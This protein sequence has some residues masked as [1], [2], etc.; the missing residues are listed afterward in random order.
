M[1]VCAR[2]NCGTLLLK[3][4]GSTDYKKRFCSKE[5]KT[6]DLREKMRDKRRLA[7]DVALSSVVSRNKA[8]SA[9]VA[10]G[11]EEMVKGVMGA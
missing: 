11:V 9:T 8:R 3:P 2:A 5:C 4:D 10:T 7:K 1:R 6:A